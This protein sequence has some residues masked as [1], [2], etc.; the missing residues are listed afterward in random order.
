MP[1][2]LCR[3]HDCN[4]QVYH[5]SLCC[6]HYR[7]WKKYGDPC[8][9]PVVDT[10]G[11][12]PKGSFKNNPSEYRS[13]KNMVSR[14]TDPENDNYHYYG[15]RGIRVCDRW[16]GK[17]GLANFIEDMGER[18]VGKTLDRIDVDGDYTPDNCRWV[19]WSVQNHNKTVRRHSTNTTGVSETFNHG[20]VWYIASIS[21]NGDKRQKWFKTFNEALSWRI[22]QEKEL[23]GETS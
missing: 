6:Q 19:E 2:I 9:T 15:G 7:R 5:C 18:P 12:L 17:S 8:A 22:S 20:R 3:I 1:K 4:R 16:L 11:Y 23:Y 14:C 10:S 21:R 13:W